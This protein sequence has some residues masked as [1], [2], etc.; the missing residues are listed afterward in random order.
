MARVPVP[1][2]TKPA[3]DFVRLSE[4]LR[5]WTKLS[6]RASFV[7]T[8]AEKGMGLKQCCQESPLTP[9]PPPRRDAGGGGA[10]GSRLFYRSAVAI[11]R[12]MI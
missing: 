6:D 10:S 4:H 5:A 8:A 1:Q 11:Y 2:N 7:S 9:P 3:C 12:I